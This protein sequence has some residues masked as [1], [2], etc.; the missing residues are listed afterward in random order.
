MYKSS[1]QIK[2]QAREQILGRFSVLIPSIILS[3]VLLFILTTFVTSFVNRTTFTGYLIGVSITYIV[4]IVGGIFLVGYIVQNLKIICHQPYSISD[5]FYGFRNQ[6]NKIIILRF[7]ILTVDFLSTLPLVILVYFMQTNPSYSILSATIL[8]LIP[9]IAVPLF[10][11]LQFSMANYLLVDFPDYEIP[12]LLRTSIKIM[13]GHRLRLLYIMVGFI[14]LF[15]LGLLSFGIG[16]LWVLSYFRM[17]L[18]E[19]YLDLMSK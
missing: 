1:T 15:L 19:F 9:A 12:E 17:T 7:F 18:T 14:P 6:T 10:M 5:I 2:A 4:D 16:N 3:Q 11:E 8:S 13:K